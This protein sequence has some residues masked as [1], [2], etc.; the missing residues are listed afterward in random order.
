MPLC[1]CSQAENSSLSQSRSASKPAHVDART[2]TP[3]VEPEY[4]KKQEAEE[5]EGAEE[6]QEG[7]WEDGAEEP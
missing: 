1:L 3:H 4:T 6:D 2:C 7:D 5:A